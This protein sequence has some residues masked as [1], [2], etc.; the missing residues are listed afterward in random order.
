MFCFN[1]KFKKL[2]PIKSYTPHTKV[3]KLVIKAVLVVPTFCGF[4]EALGIEQYVVGEWVFEVMDDKTPGVRVWYVPEGE[5]ILGGGD[6]FEVGWI[7]DQCFC[8]LLHPKEVV[9]TQEQ[10]LMELYEKYG[11][12]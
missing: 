10:K 3:E 1:R 5:Y 2:T 4:H 7:S 9:K 8:Y 11:I 6:T 12:N